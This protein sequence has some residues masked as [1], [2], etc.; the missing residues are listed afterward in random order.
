LGP[1]EELQ[2][3]SI[4]ILFDRGRK[5][6]VALQYIVKRGDSLSGLAG[7]HLGHTSQWPDLLDFHNDQVGRSGGDRGRL[8]RINDPNMLFVGQ[9]MFLPIRDKKIIRTIRLKGTQALPK[10]TALPIDLYI[11]Y[12][13]R[14]N[15]KPIIHVQECPDCLIKA[16]MRGKISIAIDSAERYL[17]NLELLRSQNA[18][19][20]KNKLSVVY[21]PAISA[22][23]AK[24]DMSFKAGKVMI[25]E[26]FR[27][28]PGE[29]PQSGARTARKNEK[30]RLLMIE[31]FIISFTLN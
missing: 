18:I 22:I 6:I 7:R 12:T 23:L 14:Q 2:D 3:L 29:S 16:E 4:V 24:P 19:E 1:D 5:S 26:P 25:A 27:A 30:Q 15:E 21:N 28:N 13:I 17:H 31:T 20:C 8:F 9:I 10:R 11:E